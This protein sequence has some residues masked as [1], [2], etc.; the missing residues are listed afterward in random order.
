MRLGATR[1]W[2]RGASG[3]LKENRE[4][5]MSDLVTG[6]LRRA[7]M[8]AASVTA[9]TV[10]LAAQAQSAAAPL[11][12]EDAPAI[13]IRSDI[14]PDV[15]P[16]GG[17]LD[18]TVNVTGVGQMRLRPSQASTGGFVC[19]GTLINPRTVIFAAHCV[20]SSPA[21]ALGFNSGGQAISF[22]FEANNNPAVRL[23]LGLASTPGGTDA[24]PALFQNKTNAARHL[25]NVEQVYYDPRSLQPPGFAFLQADVALATLD[26]HADNEPTWAMLFSPLT[27]P[28]HALI[29]GYGARGAS[30]TSGANLGVDSRRR[31]AENMIDFLG[32][33]DD[34][35]RLLFTDILFSGRSTFRCGFSLSA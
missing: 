28:T 29:N 33:L 34:R 21:S 7:L 32:S 30:G 16:P 31:I 35:D 17:S 6:N 25:Y 5:E 11:D 3:F 2:A 9:L 23:W 22:G 4:F 10:P 24:N 14:L 18:N 13:V 20:N 26:T 27:G 8:L 12:S 15:N 1:Y 19:T